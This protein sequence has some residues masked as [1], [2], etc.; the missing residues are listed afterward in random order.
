MESLCHKIEYLL[1]CKLEK[2]LRKQYALPFVR[3]AVEGKL[4][5]LA[6]KLVK[7]LDEEEK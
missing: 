4:D 7:M 1:T 5:E 2:E 6:E 3:E